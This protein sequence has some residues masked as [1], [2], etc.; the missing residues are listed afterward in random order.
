VIH[1]PDFGKIILGK[2]SVTHEDYKQ[3]TKTP[4][5]STVRL[6]MIDFQL[7]CAVDGHLS[8]DDGSTNGTT[9]P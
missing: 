7:G 9:I 5:K 8:L 3:G 2:V 6:T 1:V 4:R